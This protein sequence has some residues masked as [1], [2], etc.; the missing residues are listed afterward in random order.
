MIKTNYCIFLPFIFLLASILSHISVV[1]QDSFF[2][3]DSIVHNLRFANPK[4]TIEDIEKACKLA[5]IH[6]SIMSLENGYETN[7]N[8]PL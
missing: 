3:N 7:G 6:D 4:A 8:T 2:F 5:K 1:S